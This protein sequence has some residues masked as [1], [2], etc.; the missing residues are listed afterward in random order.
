MW[1]PAVTTCQANVGRLSMVKI[2]TI[3]PMVDATERSKVPGLLEFKD[4]LRCSCRLFSSSSR[5]R[6]NPICISWIAKVP[7]VLGE[8]YFHETHNP[9]FPVGSGGCPHSQKEKGELD[10]LSP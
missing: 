4:D 7:L 3:S 2:H 10:E 6:A 5:L 9:P 1:L 8:A